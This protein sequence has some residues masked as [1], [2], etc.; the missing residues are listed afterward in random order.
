[1]AEELLQAKGDY[2]ELGKNWVSKY[3]SR[4]PMLQAKYSRTLDQDRFLAQDHDIIQD[5]FNLYQST[6]AEHGILDEDTYNMDE[7]GYMMGIAGSSK[8]VFSKY[9]KQAFIN[10]PGNREWAS[11][12]K[13]ISGTGERLPLFVIFKGKKMER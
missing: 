3:L 13:A 2:K 7:N 6:K 11:L 5:W 12:I 9:Q 10:Q 1:M 4:H 8:V